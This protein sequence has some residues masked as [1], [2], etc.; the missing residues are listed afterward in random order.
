MLEMRNY[1]TQVTANFDKIITAERYS[2]GNFDVEHS[3][4]EYPDT[5]VECN[6]FSIY[7]TGESRF[8]SKIYYDEFVKPIF[9]LQ[10]TSY[11]ALGLDELAEYI[12]CMNEGAEVVK[13]LTEKYIKEVR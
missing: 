5:K 7:Y 3:H 9:T 8:G 6:V 10:T 4:Y 2:I 1:K 12:D 13:F 11:G